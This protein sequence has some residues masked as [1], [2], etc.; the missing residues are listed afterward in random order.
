MVR[1]FRLL[2]LAVAV[3]CT[4]SADKST[5]SGAPA[6]TEDSSTPE[7]T[8]DTA[9]SGERD[10][11]SPD[12][13]PS[14]TREGHPADGWG[15]EKHGALFEDTVALD[16]NE[17][18]LA[19]TLVATDTG[20]HLLFARK[21]GTEN[22]LMVATSSDGVAWSAPEA[23]TG[24]DADGIEYPS[25][26]YRDGVFHLWSG[27]G[28]VAY[29]TSTDGRDFSAGETVLRAGEP[30]AFDGLS[31]LYPHAV[32]SDDGVVLYYTGYDGARFTIGRTEASAPGDEF[33]SGTALLEADPEGWDNTS[34]G[35]PEVVADSTGAE[36]FFYGGY[37]T[38]IANPGPWRIGLW[39][40]TTGTRLVSL[41]LAESGLDAWSTRDPAIVPQGDGWLMVYVGMG[42]D[43][44]YRLLRATSAVC[45]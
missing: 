40:P 20:F 39:D 2:P 6:S 24:L 25:L 15:W 17:G 19:P 9:D 12:S 11:V 35:M 10:C 36:H 32:M 38:V 34:V 30:G 42:D 45:N 29:A 4:A 13:A 31:L 27:S 26:V 28:S 5:D 44:I 8:A 23:V 16:Y 3:A 37:D 33:P 43:G 41:P 18:D 14:D 21:V 7:D 1:V 22:T